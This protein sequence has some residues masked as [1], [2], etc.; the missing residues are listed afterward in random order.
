MKNI[1]TKDLS[2]NQIFLLPKHG[3]LMIIKNKFIQLLKN[4]TCWHKRLKTAT[5]NMLIINNRMML[6][7]FMMNPQNQIQMLIN[8]RLR[9]HNKL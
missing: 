9:T 8:L 6:Y 4:F 1:F 5:M 2:E 3:F 7:S